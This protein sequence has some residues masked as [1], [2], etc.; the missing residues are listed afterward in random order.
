M[1]TAQQTLD[2]ARTQLG[3]E[4]PGW[5]DDD[6]GDQFT[7]YGSWFAAQ[8]GMSAY[9]DTYWCQMF[10][11]WVLHHAGFGTEQVGMYGN[12]NPAI[13]YW[14]TR[15]RW[16][17]KP[18][19][20]DVVYYSWNGDTIAEH[21]GF[22]EAPLSDGR[23]Q[24]IEGN[25]TTSGVRDGVRRLIRNPAGIV[26]GY[27]RPPYTAPTST[28]DDM[29]SV[30]QEQWDRVRNQLDKLDDAVCGGQGQAYL[31]S[32]MRQDHGFQIDEIDRRIHAAIAER[33]APVTAKLDQL[34]TALGRPPAGS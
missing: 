27:A 14:R 28:G 7:K 15:G 29:A 24:V 17:A 1:P 25:A 19:A 30:P 22:V 11:T 6:A 18:H 33:L 16:T 8:T 31:G 13:S 26:L 23:I 34:L 2:L 21:V 4:E 9:Q 12:C 10:V 32:R 5:G 20:G 3:Y